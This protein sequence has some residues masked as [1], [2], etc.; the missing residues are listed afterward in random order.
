M[1]HVEDYIDAGLA[2]LRAQLPGRIAAVNAEKP[3]LRVPTPDTDA[4]YPGG[5][6]VFLKYPSVELAAPDWT[7]ANPSLGQRAWDGNVTV[8]GRILMQHPEFD[9]LYR[10]VMRYG[11]CLVEVLSKQDALGTGVTVQQMRGFYRVNPETGERDEF[12]AGALVVCTL[13][14]TEA[15]PS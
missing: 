11:R 7:L 4:Y 8:T 6:S 12:I 10:M 9:V 13:D 3:D 15:T 5:L 1:R 14:V 2:S